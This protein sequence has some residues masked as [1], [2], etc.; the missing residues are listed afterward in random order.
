M[1]VIAFIKIWSLLSLQLFLNIL[2]RDQNQKSELQFSDVVTKSMI[3][4][5]CIHYISYMYYIKHYISLYI[6]YHICE[7][8]ENVE[9]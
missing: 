7:E 1:K 8:S 9:N 2:I 4:H 6:I 3:Y 5:I